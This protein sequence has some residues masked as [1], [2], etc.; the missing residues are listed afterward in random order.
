MKKEFI[1]KTLC[2][3]GDSILQHGYYIYNLRSYFQGKKEKCFVYNR[4]VAG[5]RAIMAQYILG[6]EAYWL[7]PDYAVICFGVN[8]L[9]VWLYDSMKPITEEVLFKRKARDDEY[10]KAHEILLDELSAKGITPIIMSPYA[11]NE[12]IVENEEVETVND[13]KEK[14]DEIKPSFYKRKTFQNINEALK[15]YSERLQKLCEEKGVE[16]WDIFSS[17]YE[18]ML[19]KPEMFGVDGI[20]YTEGKGHKE[21]AKSVLQCLG[22][23]IP[24]GFMKTAENDKIFALEQFERSIGY[25]A[26]CAPMNRLF[27]DYTEADIVDYAQKIKDDESVYSGSRISARNYLAHR[28]E[29]PQIK[30][31]LKRLTE[32]L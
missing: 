24:D 8:D 22:C 16:F 5:N 17:T 9:G 25:I 29:L 20:H 14:E 23:D 32:N 28:H 13:N 19:T 30:M 2:F 12:F 15:G 1:G 3:I 11:V 18:K 4:G 10:I 21:I 26:R 6:D 27:G 7:K 31:E